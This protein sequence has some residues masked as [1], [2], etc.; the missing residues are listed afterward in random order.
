M[1]NPMTNLEACTDE[2]LEQE[3]AR[4]LAY[5]SGELLNDAEVQ[6]F[7]Q[8]HEEIQRR[9]AP[10]GTVDLAAGGFEC[11]RDISTVI[12]WQCHA[13]CF[14]ASQNLFFVLS[15]HLRAHYRHPG[16]IVST[17]S[18]PGSQPFQC[19]SSPLICSGG[20]SRREYPPTGMP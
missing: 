3:L 7:Y 18:T 12:G 20:C 10:S 8:L 2:E 5:A 17:V 11:N 1:T 4:M 13:I 9:R 6:K 16:N 14:L 19:T 15:R